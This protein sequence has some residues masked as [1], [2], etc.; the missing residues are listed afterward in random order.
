MKHITINLR[1][2]GGNSELNDVEGEDDDTVTIHWLFL[3]CS[4]FVI[5]YEV[6]LLTVITVL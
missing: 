2:T 4:V 3:Y 6:I 5:I 1:D